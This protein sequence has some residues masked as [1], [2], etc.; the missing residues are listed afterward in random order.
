MSGWN[1]QVGMWNVLWP[2]MVMGL[3]FSAQHSPAR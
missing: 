1:L 2:N 3:G